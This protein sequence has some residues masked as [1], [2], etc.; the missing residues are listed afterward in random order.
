M[1][2]GKVIDALKTIRQCCIESVRCEDCPLRRPLEP[3]SCSLTGA[4]MNRNPGDWELEQRTWTTSI[5]FK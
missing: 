3:D 5:L 1:E 2:I 4:F